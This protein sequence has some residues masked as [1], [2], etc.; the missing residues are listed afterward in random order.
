MAQARPEDAG[1][2]GRRIV[3]TGGG[4]GLGRVVAEDLLAHGA[5]VVIVG[6][7]SEVPQ[8][9][10]ENSSG[11]AVSA[12]VT[13]RDRLAAAF[14][15]ADAW[16]GGI[17]VVFANAGLSRPGPLATTAPADFS[18]VLETN[19]VGTLLTLQAAVPYLA[20]SGAGRFIALSSALAQRIAPGAG[21]YSISKSAIETLVRV[22][23]IELAP[24]SISVNA[25][26]P[27]FID[28]GM[29]SNLIAN[30]QVWDKYLPTIAAGR[31]GR[32]EEVAGVARFLAG[33]D[34]GYVNGHVL[35]VNGGL[36]F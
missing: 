17:D 33:P 2:A 26:S 19:V 10:R 3:I 34:S 13:D 15:E 4:R 32:G 25:L 12:D 23:A 18:A 30:Q 29:G 8:W 31:P 6:R 27:G 5:R 22:A 35:E 14:T 21:A 28:E 11:H 20:A 24:Q 1:L 16:L 9:I 7:D 36:S